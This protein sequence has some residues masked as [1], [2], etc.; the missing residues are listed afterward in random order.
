MQREELERTA[1]TEEPAQM[2]A[3]LEAQ[4]EEHE[5]TIALQ[6][7]REAALKNELAGMRR[8]YEQKSLDYDEISDAFFWKI[9]K[10]ARK[11]MD[12]VK[13]LLRNSRLAHRAWAGM[14][15]VKNRIV[16]GVRP[17]LTPP[18]PVFYQSGRPITV[19]CT[20]HTRYVGMLIQHALARAG[21]SA[22]IL[23]EEPKEYGEQVYLVVC[24]QMFSKMPGRYIAFQMEQTVS[25]RWLTESYYDRLVHAYAV[26][27]YSLINIAFFRRTCEFGKNF[28]YLPIDW[29]PGLQRQAG[30]YAYDV[31]FYGDVNNPRR[32]AMLETLRE[33][34]SVKI[35]SEVFGQE[36]Y[37]ELSR[38]KIVINLH[39]YEGAMLETTRLY[40]TLSLGRSV[41]VSERSSDPE[42][43]KRLEGI[44]DFVPAG[45]TAAM[46]ERI[47]WWLSHE[48]E[49]AAA[50]ERNNR[51]LAERPR[52][53]DYF[54]F[55]FLL[56]N[57]W[58]SFDRF[59]ELAGDYISLD[60]NR[61]CLSLPEATDR[62]EAFDRDN[63]FGFTV[64]PGLRH[65]RGWTGCGLSYKFLMKKAREQHMEDILICED[66][67]LFPE[68]FEQRWERCRCYLAECGDW[69][70]FQGIMADVSENAIQCVRHRDGETFVHL[71]H[72]ISMVFNYYKNTVYDAVTAWDE[73]NADAYSNTIDRALE[74]RKLNVVTTLP[75]LVGHK[76]D[77]KSE[78]WGF[79]NS[80]YNETITKS[81]EKLTR[82]VSA[83][84]ERR[85]T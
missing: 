31:V 3:R 21:I 36:L 71:N 48:E 24:P 65:Q 53:F 74:A 61:I 55:R 66:D 47:A 2:I 25:S 58:I 13:Y 23:T 30:P 84:E 57:D 8:L 51:V 38:A 20:R 70:L 56:A 82:L 50:V 10:P 52:A 12:R 7:A 43:E 9:T 68:N 80:Q 79:Q 67:V 37:D 39:Y 16:L 69:D 62:R 26:L 54:F 77:L 35:L 60:G 17:R 6:K 1:V 78:V 75:F 72:A 63:R 29:L 22:D 44:V 42:E 34:F 59:Y 19:L 15:D 41:I 83:F 45:D 5:R 81:S 49:R 18:P 73:S 40:E 28:Y 76:E 46:A 27:D 11:T 64:F 4:L 33:R 85:K 14:R 32:K